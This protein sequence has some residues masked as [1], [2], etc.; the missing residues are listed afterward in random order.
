VDELGVMH[1]LKPEILIVEPRMNT[2][3]HG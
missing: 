1:R 2:D 3:K